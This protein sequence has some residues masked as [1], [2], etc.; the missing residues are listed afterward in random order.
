MRWYLLVDFY[1]YAMNLTGHGADQL[2]FYDPR[3]QP[4]GDIDEL[5]SILLDVCHSRAHKTTINEIAVKFYSKLDFKHLSD[6]IKCE[7]VISKDVKIK[8]VRAKE[9]W[10]WPR[11]RWVNWMVVVEVLAE[12]K[13]ALNQWITIV[14]CIQFDLA[15]KR[16]RSVKEIRLN[17]NIGGTVSSLKQAIIKELELELRKA[18]I[19]RLRR[20]CMGN[21]IGVCWKML[22]WIRRVRS[23]LQ[24]IRLFYCFYIII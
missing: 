14:D 1:F 2:D 11:R 23:L 6:K 7:L 5:Q 9:L 21:S 17:T 8:E 24:L 18:F 15:E 12:E 20:G 10:K 3:K 22:A 16:Y 19:C 4:M 13:S